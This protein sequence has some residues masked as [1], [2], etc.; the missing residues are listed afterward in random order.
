MT[1][2]I[3]AASALA[4]LTLFMAAALLTVAP[5][6]QPADRVATAYTQQIDG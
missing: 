3:A 1:Q 4:A 6:H 2:T 5:S